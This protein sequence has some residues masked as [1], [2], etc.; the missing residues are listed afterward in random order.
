MR[1]RF[2]FVRVLFK[3]K[4][5]SA[6]KIYFNTVLYSQDLINRKTVQSS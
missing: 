1:S 2:F 6:A 3:V 4:K 5:L